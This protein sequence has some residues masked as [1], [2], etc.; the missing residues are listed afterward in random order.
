MEFEK[1]LDELFGLTPGEFV[2]RRDALAREARGDGDAASAAALAKLRRPTAG[3]WLANL[4]VRAEVR[5]VTEL[6][7]LGALMRQAQSALDGDQ[8][9]VL[10]RERAQVVS[11]LAALARKHAAA[12]GQPAG[13]PA[14]RDL[15]GT[16][17]AAMADA[18]AG[19]RL[20]TGRLETGLASTATGFGELSPDA[21]GS[22]KP[23]KPVGLHAVDTVGARRRAEAVDRAERELAQARLRAAEAEQLAAVARSA[24]AEAEAAASLADEAVSQAQSSLAKAQAEQSRH[25]QAP[26]EATA[27]RPRGSR[28]S[29]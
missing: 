3:A 22:A 27:P 24:L 28:R 26:A 14:L 16:L 23:L 4:L 12:A 18:A 2:K 11:A 19:E 9:R 17:S 15:E 8:I 7:E 29:G 5:K 21:G 13:D 10:G 6:V 25:E 1:A 20:L